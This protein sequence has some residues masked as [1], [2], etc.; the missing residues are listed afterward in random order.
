MIGLLAGILGIG[1][2]VLLNIPINMVIKNLTGISNITSLPIV[3]AIVLVVISMT[4]TLI[5]GLIPSRMASKKNPV[6]ALRSE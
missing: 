2:T 3:G 1:I 6:E 4:L 5:A